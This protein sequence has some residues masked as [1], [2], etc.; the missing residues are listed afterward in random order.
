MFH[1]RE[2][3]QLENSNN[4]S[5]SKSLVTNPWPTLRALPAHKSWPPPFQQYCTTY[6]DCIQRNVNPLSVG[7]FWSANWIVRSKKIIFIFFIQDNRRCSFRT[8][9]RES[10]SFIGAS[11]F[12]ALNLKVKTSDNRLVNYPN[13][14][15]RPILKRDTSTDSRTQRSNFHAPPKLK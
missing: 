12:Y 5:T 1:L 14:C 11:G 8:P 2:C 3:R 9:D 10:N 13:S 7:T 4:S 6:S 15:T